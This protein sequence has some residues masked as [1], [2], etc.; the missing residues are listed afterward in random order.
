MNEIKTRD[1]L[2][3]CLQR[4]RSAIRIFL[5]SAVLQGGVF[6]LYG[7]PPEPF[8]YA[9]ALVSVSVLALLLADAARTRRKTGRLENAAVALENGS[10]GV[11]DGDTLAERIYARMLASAVKKAEG[12]GTELAAQRQEIEDYATVW[13]H[14]IKT[15]VAV[16]RLMLKETDSALLAELFRIEQYAEMALSYIRLGGSD[17]VIRAYSVDEMVRETVRKYASQ[18]I[19]R[20]LKLVYEPS[21]GSVVTDKKWCCC[22]LEQLLSN[23]VKYTPEEGTITI[24]AD[25]NGVTVRDTGIGIAKEDLPRIFEKGFTGLNGRKEMKASGLGLYL[26]KKAAALINAELSAESEPGRGSSFTLTFPE[27]EI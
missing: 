11:P 20:R 8:L 27:R 7:L 5:V 26:S 17:L 4:N 3:D 16:M 6:Y 21:A 13:V 14:E 25:G 22:I 18:F 15:P 12:L 10:G 19:A 9:E 24:T 2:R 23:A 1:I